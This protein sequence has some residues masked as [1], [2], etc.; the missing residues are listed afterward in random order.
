MYTRKDYPPKFC[1]LAIES[2]YS[3]PIQMH[4]EVNDF[5]N[6]TASVFNF[7]PLLLLVPKILPVSCL[8]SYPPG[9]MDP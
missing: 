4:D 8:Y 2:A 9:V 3:V 6:I 5:G 7:I 1:I